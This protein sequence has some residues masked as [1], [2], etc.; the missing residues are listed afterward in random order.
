MRSGRC[1]ETATLILVRST[2]R[3]RQ[4]VTHI[5]HITARTLTW[6][7]GPDNHPDSAGLRDPNERQCLLALCG[8][9][10]CP[11]YLSNAFS[12][13]GM[14]SPPSQ[15]PPIFGF[16]RESRGSRICSNSCPQPRQKPLFMRLD[17]ILSHTDA[18]DIWEMRVR[19]TCV[20]RKRCAVFDRT[21]LS[22]W[23][24]GSS[25]TLYLPIPWRV[26]P[27]DDT[28]RDSTEC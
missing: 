19:K 28:V 25:C 6:D 20:Q 13:G 9:C 17:R 24:C 3:M 2:C 26:V 10:S 14:P 12:F 5:F 1:I 8:E 11:E 21:R 23:R 7:F 27:F 16:S 18:K 15:P 22:A 4:N